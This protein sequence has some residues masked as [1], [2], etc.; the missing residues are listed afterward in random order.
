MTQEWGKR[1][2]GNDRTYCVSLHTWPKEGTHCLIP[3]ALLVVKTSEFPL[4]FLSL[5]T[6]NQPLFSRIPWPPNNPEGP[7]VFTVVG[8]HLCVN[9]SDNLPTQGK[10]HTPENWTQFSDIHIF[11]LCHPSDKF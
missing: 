2:K 11:C 1:S 6:L 3:V 10:G 7:F 9:V 8:F 5:H 4:G